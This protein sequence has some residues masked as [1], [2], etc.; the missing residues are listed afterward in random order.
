MTI[1][2]RPVYGTNETIITFK[3]GN[4][5][6]IPESSSSIVVLDAE[7]EREAVYAA[8]AEESIIKFLE[9]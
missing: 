2:T 4:D 3:K 6:D 7:N 8:M 9:S 1:I 5:S